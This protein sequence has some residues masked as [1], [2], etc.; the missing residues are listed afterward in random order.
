MLKIVI[1]RR[2]LIT[3][4]CCLFAAFFA[5][6]ARA[7]CPPPLGPTI[8]PL[9][10]TSI[11]KMNL[12]RVPTGILEDF[13]ETKVNLA[14]FDGVTALC[15][16]NYVN[17]RTLNGI[18][19]GLA[20]SR[21]NINQTIPNDITSQMSQLYGNGVNPVAIVAYKYSRTQEHAVAN[22]LI[23]VVNGRYYDAFD[24]GGN[25]VNP[26]EDKYVVAFSP[27]M[28]VSGNQVTYK[29]A[30]EIRY[31]NL[32]IFS[33]QFDAGD[34]MG[35]RPITL[36]GN[37]SNN[38]Q[39]TYSSP[40][41][42]VEL[43]LKLTLAGGQILEA[44]SYV[45]V[46]AP[47]SNSSESLTIDN[48]KDF[49]AE[50]T[51][52][53][54][55]NTVK[56]IISVKYANGVSLT[57]P[58]IIAEGFDLPG[59]PDGASNPGDSMLGM[60][61]LN[62]FYG[63]NSGAECLSLG[64]DLVYVDWLDSYAPIQAN[65]DILK[66][67]IDW[68]NTNKTGTNKN[69][70]IGQSMGGLIARYTLR[71]MELAG[72]P[73]DVKVYVSE[74]TPHYGVNVPIGYVYFLQKVLG[75][76][77]Q[78][79][80]LF[81]M[82]LITTLTSICSIEID[83]QELF[84]IRNA[85]SV[86]QMLMHYV[87]SDYTYDSQLYDSFQATLNGLGYPQGDAG[88]QIINLTISN[89]GVN[90]Y[91][92]NLSY[93]M[94]LDWDV[95][96]TNLYTWGLSSLICYSGPKLQLAI[97]PLYSGTS[98]V[99][100]YSLFWKKYNGFLAGLTIPLGSD[101][102]DAPTSPKVFDDDAGSYYEPPT[103]I[104]VSICQ[105]NLTL[106][107]NNRIMF[108]PSVSSLA[109]KKQRYNLQTSDRKIDFAT[110]GLDMN[111]LPFAG[112]KFNSDT[113][114]YHTNIDSTDIRWMDRM[115][116]LTIASSPDTLQTGYTFQIADTDPNK[117]AFSV[118][119]SVEDTSVATIGSSSGTISRVLGGTTTAYA[120]ITFNGG[121]F[122]LSRDFYMEQN[123]FPG[124][125]TYV[126]T[127]TPQIAFGDDEFSGDYT[128]HSTASSHVPSTFRPFMTCH[129]GV[130]ANTNSSVQWSTAP[131]AATLQQLDFLCHFSE[132]ASCRT[133]YF[134]VTFNTNTTSPTYSI[135]CERPPVHYVL[136]SNGYMYA[137]DMD[138]PFAQVKGE[139]MDE[140]YYFKCTDQTLVYNHWPTW[141]EFGLDMLKSEEFVS[142]IKT[143]KP[144]GE[145]ELL[146]IPYSYHTKEQEEEK[147]G[148]ITVKYDPTL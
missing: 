58:L 93:H 144:L 116:C 23:N 12:N 110:A 30:P 14:T 137:P 10:D 78:S 148:I 72:N 146:L 140:V 2:I 3:G 76:L 38:V 88:Q 42:P 112:Y 62:T 35:Y 80:S 6:P 107:L 118:V 138:E 105:D 67:V 104:G 75:G 8:M 109:Y 26:Y 106:F 71:T 121:H 108:V 22:N 65:A 131:Y 142:L 13:G 7:L 32:H 5:N 132:L 63:K 27:Y 37:N 139:V 124:F 33:I 99:Y 120:D 1:P 114:T 69:I 4:L 90:T 134:K 98:R 127:K 61:T 49:E 70:I 24:N 147:Q 51:Y 103:P 44:H 129:W 21:V 133:V 79:D 101:Y 97:Y 145:E 91:T 123:P 115:T 18:L 85:P 34:G 92:S 56:A 117:G 16:T 74:D 77:S 94:H 96:C 136:D 20:S 141:T 143:L 57:N 55:Q 128:I 54:Y 60:N 68:V 73:H 83:P 122:R 45:T 15:D 64:Y 53:G 40:T 48:S 95:A 25:W 29:I 43:K 36:F 9:L 89:G 81:S 46:F 66:Q 52:L 113:S 50:S 31:S 130:K 126:L 111:N 39:V 82:D 100:E 11:F 86:R 28:N 41:N 17:F 119:W 135:I 84:N 59:N 19:S 102:F 87:S 47:S 125:P